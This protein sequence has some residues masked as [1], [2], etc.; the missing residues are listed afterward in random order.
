M[1]QLMD[2]MMDKIIEGLGKNNKKFSDS[3]IKSIYQHA[4]DKS[5]LRHFAATTCARVSVGISSQMLVES[6]K[7]T[8]EALSEDFP[9]F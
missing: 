9:E 2:A 7:K 6:W 3:Q 4:H 5:K 1:S 8:I